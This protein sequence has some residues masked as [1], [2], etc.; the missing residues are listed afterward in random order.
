M[1]LLAVLFCT[2]LRGARLQEH[3]VGRA[4]ACQLGLLLSK[5]Q[6]K[7]RLLWNS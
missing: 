5:G 6:S 2:L 7:Q 1:V 3:K 4:G